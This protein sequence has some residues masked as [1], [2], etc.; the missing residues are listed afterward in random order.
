MRVLVTGATGFL[1]RELCSTLAERRYDLVCLGRRPSEFGKHI[2]WDLRSKL[3][4][5]PDLTCDIIL[6]LG[7]TADFST[8]F[9]ADIYE[10]NTIGTLKLCQLSEREAAILSYLAGSIG[11]AISREEILQ[12]V[13]GLNPLH[14]ETRT[15]DMH[16]ARLRDKL[17]D[18]GEQ[19]RVI[20]TVRSKG[21]MLV[22][23]AEIEEQ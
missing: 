13:W 9:N 4:E 5:G 21:Y 8:Q 16:I 20:L 17:D 22:E 3:P 23:C 11:R 7:A 19:D 15:V 14:L 18:R 6:H 2:E 1:G 12:R 10:T